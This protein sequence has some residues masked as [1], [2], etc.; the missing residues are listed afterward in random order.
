MCVYVG[1]CVLAG[2]REAGNVL[3]E[4]GNAFENGSDPGTELGVV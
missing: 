4:A 2:R 1:E 3:E